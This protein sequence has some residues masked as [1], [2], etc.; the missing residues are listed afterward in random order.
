MLKTYDFTRLL[1][2]S[3]LLWVCPPL[4]AEQQST[5]LTQAVPLFQEASF[6]KTREA[7][8]LLAA[9]ADPEVV[10]YLQALL[11][12]KLYQNKAQ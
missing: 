7:V 11:D 12:G 1:L 10:P 2:L 4:Q 5:I 3:L 6:D 8:D 9:S